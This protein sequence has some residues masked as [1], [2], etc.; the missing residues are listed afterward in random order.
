MHNLNKLFSIFRF[1]QPY[2]LSKLVAYFQ[3]GTTVTTSDLYLYASLVIALNIVTT[4]YNHNYQQMLAEI[5]IKVRTAVT[6]LV[7]RKTLKLSPSALSDVTMGKIVTLITR[8]V[9]S[10]ENALIFINDMWISVIQI[11]LISY[12]IFNRIG[13]SV[14]AGVGFYL[15]TIPLQG[16]SK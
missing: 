9:F 4:L 2:A 14:F 7:F 3:H 10:F 12:L 5:G 11:C 6:A 8:D 16:E 13:W 15:G 1:V